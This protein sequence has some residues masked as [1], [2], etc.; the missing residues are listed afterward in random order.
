VGNMEEELSTDDSGGGGGGGVSVAEVEEEV[1]IVPVYFILSGTAS[2]IIHVREI[3]ITNLCL[4]SL[5]IG[6]CNLKKGIFFSPDPYVKFRI[7]GSGKRGEAPATASAASGGSGEHGPSTSRA[8]PISAHGRT[9]VRRNTV[10]PIWDGEEFQFACNQSDWIEVEI[11]DKFAKSRPTISRNLG[12]LR[13]SVSQLL[14]DV[15]PGY[16]RMDRRLPS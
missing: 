12:K 11:K 10:D 4:C 9:N 7:S 1:E 15:K 6:A 3:M 2:F 8:S 14:Q 5:D 13:I 16:V